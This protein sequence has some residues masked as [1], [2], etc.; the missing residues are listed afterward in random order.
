MMPLEDSH[1]SATLRLTVLMNLTT[2]FIFAD[3]TGHGHIDPA[4]NY[5]QGERGQ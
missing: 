2:S 5:Q 3:H 1:D 4:D